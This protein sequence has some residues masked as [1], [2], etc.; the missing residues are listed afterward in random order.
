MGTIVPRH[1]VQLELI[2]ALSEGLG[3]DEAVAAVAARLCIAEE[4]VREVVA[5]LE[6]STQ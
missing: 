3:V 4:A 5:E 6:G 2:R 1:A